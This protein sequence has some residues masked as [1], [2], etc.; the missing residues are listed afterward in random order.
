MKFTVKTSPLRKAFL[1]ATKVS[2]KSAS[3]LTVNAQV[4]YD[5]QS[6]SIAI[7]AT[8]LDVCMFT[9]IP[10]E[11][12]EGEVIPS[13]LVQPGPVANIL[14]DYKGE[15]VTFDV[16]D[17]LSVLLEKGSYTFVIIKTEQIPFSVNKSYDQQFTMNSKVFLDTI[18]SF[19]DICKEDSM[20]PAL[21]CVLFDV[22]ES[23]IRVV[24]TD[25]KKLLLK[26]VDN[27]PYLSTGKLF[28]RKAIVPVLK[29]LIGKETDCEL[30]VSF[31]NMNV[32]VKF[33]RNLIT[34]KQ[35]VAVFPSYDNLFTTGATKDLVVNKEEMLDTL[36]RMNSCS[37]KLS[38]HIKVELTENK[39]SLSISNTSLQIGGT[40]SIIVEY[41]EA[42][43]FVGYALNNLLQMLKVFPGDKVK[44]SFTDASHATILHSM[45]EDENLSG[46]LMPVRLSNK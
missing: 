17:S 5:A 40:E 27:G 25:T 32:E 26:H 10:V 21:E 12:F 41:K 4:D 45:N 37:D 2:S 13:F 36:K 28:I 11:S 31:D 23:G 34:C 14:K 38:N 46:L 30:E 22:L 24:A 16:N 19:A 20:R 1:N 29:E 44:F 8:D 9:S 42:P 18:S 33:D 43:L 39:M 7:K 6:N 15:S 3:P 35:V